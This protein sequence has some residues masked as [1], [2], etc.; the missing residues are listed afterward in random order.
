MNFIKVFVS[1]IVTV[2]ML[3][4]LCACGSVSD[5]TTTDTT[6]KVT[7]VTDTDE[8]TTTEDDSAVEGKVT[9]T[10]KVVDEENNPIA[11]AMVQLCL[12]A[13][14]PRVTDAAGVAVYELEEADYKVSFV[15][16]PEGYTCEE[17][18]F[19]FADGEYELTITLKAE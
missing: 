14:V 9:Y 11:G 7:N 8:S 15:S 13:C 18:E 3:V 2:F 10:V 19:H 1:L 12:D 17:N 16:M 6:D 4:S 5:E